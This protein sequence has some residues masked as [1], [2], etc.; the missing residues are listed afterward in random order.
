[1]TEPPDE[2]LDNT[3]RCPQGPR[4]ESCGTEGDDVAVSAVQTPVGMLCLS[5]C[6]RCATSGTP[7][8][9][10]LATAVRLVAQHLDHVR[11][12]AR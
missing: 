7:A 3:S 6:D 4:C 9:I 11:G 1:M 2:D 12:V 8:P 5:L 10:H